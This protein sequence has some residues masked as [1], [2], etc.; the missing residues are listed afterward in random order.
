[1]KCGEPFNSADNDS[2]KRSLQLDSGFELAG[3][4]VG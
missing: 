2:R 3:V 1:M 4:H